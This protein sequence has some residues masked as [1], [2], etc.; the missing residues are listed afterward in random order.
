[1]TALTDAPLVPEL[2]AGWT[3]SANAFNWT[4]EIIA[5]QRSAFDIVRAI[6]QDG[7]ATVIEVE[8]GQLWRSFPVPRPAEADALRHALDAAGASV[9][10]VGISL[11]EL[12][13]PRRR[14]EQR[15]RL[16]FLLPQLRAAHR[17]GAKGVRLPL[18]QC[19]PDLLARLLPDLHELDL[20]LYEEFQGGQVP[21]APA[22]DEAFSAIAALDDPRI[23]L[24]ADISC[25]MPQL[26]VTYLAALEAG[27]LGE[28]EVA[29]VRDR[30]DD[31][32]TAGEVMA[33]LGDGRVPDAIGPLF[34]NLFARFGRS[35]AADLRGILPY[36]GAVHLKFWDLDDDAG[37]ISGPTR[38][39][40]AEL[41]QAGFRGTLCSEWGGQEWMPDADAADMTRRHLAAAHVWLAEGAAG[42]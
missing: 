31:P 19:G 20:V 17:L 40:G 25:L 2:P 36:T 42:R 23:R 38:E 3:L 33:M 27:G 11:D 26:P 5:A 1:M 7:V 22:A 6:A 9:S 14:R 10:V 30:W 4:W 35:R 32:A 34:A 24:L 28:A 41:A 37:R 13:G 21:G 29:V 18:G 8:P 39:L 12:S 16:E 15:E